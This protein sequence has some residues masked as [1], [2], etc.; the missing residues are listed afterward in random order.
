MQKTQDSRE[1]PGSEGSE[2]AAPGPETYL[3]I[4]HSKLSCGY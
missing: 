2:V 3:P 4:L 1:T